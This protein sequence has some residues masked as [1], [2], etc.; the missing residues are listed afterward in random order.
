M[1]STQVS[2]AASASFTACRRN[3]GWWPV[4][5]VVVLAASAGTGVAA[6]SPLRYPPHHEIIGEGGSAWDRHDKSSTGTSMVQGVDMTNTVTTAI[7]NPP[8]EGPSRTPW[9]GTATV[10]PRPLTVHYGKSKK[11]GRRRSGGGL[12][13]HRSSPTGRK[14]SPLKKEKSSGHIG[15]PPDEKNGMLVPPRRIFPSAAQKPAGKGRRWAHKRH[16]GLLYQLALLIFLSLIAAAAVPQLKRAVPPHEETQ[17]AAVSEKNPTNILQIF[18]WALLLVAGFTSAGVLMASEAGPQTQ[19]H[20]T[21]PGGQQ[22]VEPQVT[23]ELTLSEITQVVL[24]HVLPPLVILCAMSAQA[25]LVGTGA[26]AMMHMTEEILQQLSLGPSVTGMFDAGG[27]RLVTLLLVTLVLGRVANSQRQARQAMQRT[28]G[29]VSGLKTAKSVITDGRERE[30]RVDERDI[31]RDE[32]VI[33]HSPQ[34]G[35]ELFRGEEPLLSESREGSSGATERYG[36]ET[37]E[38]APHAAGER[39]ASVLWKQ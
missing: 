18:V 3:L 2:P 38:S 15:L 25:A 39:T 36:G 10:G 34:A 4:V 37:G 8:E 11:R 31:S 32:V 35:T 20:P 22:P 5:I 33:G 6:T 26:L 16:S 1:M 21:T 30:E 17:S 12:Q 13:Q 28:Q 7:S 29:R 9:D 23:K 24:S 19:V 14:G 27:V